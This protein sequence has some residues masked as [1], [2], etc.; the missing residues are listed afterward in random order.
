MR[1]KTSGAGRPAARGFS[2][3]ELLVVIAIVALL[4]GVGVPN[5]QSYVVSSR[6]AGSANDMYTALNL[7]RSEAVRRQAQVTLAHNGAA[8]S[9]DWTS[10][11]TMFVDADGDGT[12]DAGEE[13]LRV[14]A[15]LDPPLTLFGSANFANFIAFDAAG[16]LTNAGGG[17][18][19][20]CHGTALVVDGEPRARAVLVNGSGRVRMALDSNGDR[21]PETDTGPVPNCNNS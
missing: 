10:G 5:M 20:L 7:A 13:V 18:F 9:R 8:G 4:L 3:I 2:L 21:I 16:R 12:L 1:S 19:V 17:S 6:L 11:W 14:G 15:A